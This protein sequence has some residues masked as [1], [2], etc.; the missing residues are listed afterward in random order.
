[1]VMLAILADFHAMPA[2][3]ASCLSKL[4]KLDGC[5]AN[6]TMVAG[7]LSWLY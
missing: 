6:L 7:S 2:M 3:Q 5:L 1:M 4:V